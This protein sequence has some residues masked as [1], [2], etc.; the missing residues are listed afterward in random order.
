[1]KGWL[2]VLIIILLSTAAWVFYFSEPNLLLVAQGP[3]LVY[4]SVDDA[5]ATLPQK[6]IAELQ[7]HQSVD[8]IQCIDVKHYQIYKVRLPDGRFGFVNEGRYVLLRNG[9]PSAC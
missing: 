3:V 6:V 1:M 5:T 2:M 4:E 8:V 7:L 9:K